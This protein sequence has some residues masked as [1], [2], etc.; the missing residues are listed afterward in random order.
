MSSQP[1]KSSL[2]SKLRACCDSWVM[3]DET[4][5]FVPLPRE[6]IL[7]TTPSRTALS[8]QTPNSYPGKEPVGIHS[9]GG[10]AFITNQRLVYLPAAPTAQ[11]QSFSAPILNL[12]DTHV[13]A[14]FF[15]PNIWT[16]ILK[17]VTGGG[18]PPHHTF[19]QIKMTF[20]DG[21]AFDFHST[22]ERVKETL[23]QAIDIARESGH[24]ARG[25]GQ[26]QGVD[27]STVHLEQLPAYEEIGNSR[28]MEPPSQVQQPIPLSPR[29]TRR[30]PSRDSGV[31]SD[32]E[33]AKPL[34]YEPSTSRQFQPPN[35]P[36]PGYEEAQQSSV[37]HNLEESVRRAQ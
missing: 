28:T 4:K 5:G 12:Q 9:T 30:A 22:F 36:P 18:L 1:S 31:S 8:L 37:V 17:P 26:M 24:V 29:S 11:L 34:S 16:G 27:L 32:N 23:S 33:S 20:K 6:H 21:G 19:I 13:S 15:G 14:P 35:E 7:F 10:T 2:L 25:S 3:L